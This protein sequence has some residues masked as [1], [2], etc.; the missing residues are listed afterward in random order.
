MSAF[1]SENSSELITARPAVP[2]CPWA[3]EPQVRELAAD[4]GPGGWEA[5]MEV[6]GSVVLGSP[7]GRGSGV[8][9]IGQ[10]QFGPSRP[11]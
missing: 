6:S 11:A 5:E 1:V 3:R 9:L 8:E 4:A 10:D 7:V 2:P